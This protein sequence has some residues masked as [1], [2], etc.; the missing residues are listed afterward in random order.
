[1]SGFELFSLQ[2][3]VPAT[4]EVMTTVISIAF[5]YSNFKNF[6]ALEHHSWSQEVTEKGGH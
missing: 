1:M 3:Y 5:I 2:S 6:K 4:K